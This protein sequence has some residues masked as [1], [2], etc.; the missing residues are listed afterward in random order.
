MFMIKKNL[1]GKKLK[2]S[3]L[4]F[5]LPPILAVFIILFVDLRLRPQVSDMAKYK[6]QGIITRAVNEV[7]AQELLKTDTDYDEW[8]KIDENS[9]GDVTFITYNSV[10]INNIKSNITSEIIKS[11]EDIGQTDIYI[12]LGN[13]TN[14]DL[15]QNKGP[16]IKFTISP[17]V[18]VETNIESEFTNT[19]INQVLHKIYVNVRVTALALI[20]NYTTTANFETK[21]CIAQVIIVG[22]VPNNI[23][24]KIF[25]LG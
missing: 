17:A 16:K 14:V 8:V 2:V 19:G 3:R 12:P 23:S 25:R 9:S 22:N 10:L 21:V 15:L 5:L 6:V 13:I 11:V 20:P 24:D 4:I 7:I 1:Y 18:Y